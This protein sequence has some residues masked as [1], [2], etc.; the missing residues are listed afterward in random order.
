MALNPSNSSN[1]EQL[2]LKGLSFESF[3]LESS[4][5]QPD[6]PPDYLLMFVYQGYWLKANSVLPKHFQYSLVPYHLKC[7]DFSG[8]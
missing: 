3:D 6:T 7:Q 8:I 5:C 1:L 4:L 2:A